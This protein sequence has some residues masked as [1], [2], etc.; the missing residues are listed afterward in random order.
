LRDYAEWYITAGILIISTEVD[1][2]RITDKE[3][4]WNGAYSCVVN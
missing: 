2:D 1:I 4:V 3:V